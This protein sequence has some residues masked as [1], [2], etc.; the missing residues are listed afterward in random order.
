MRRAAIYLATLAT[1]SALTGAFAAPAGAQEEPDATPTSS[2]PSTTAGSETP[3]SSSAEAPSSAPGSTEASKSP[4]GKPPAAKAAARAQVDVSLDFD[5][6]SYGT[7]ED[8]TF[9]LKLKNTG[10]TTAT[11][12]TMYQM[13]S[14]PTD[15][16]VPYAG[17]GDLKGWPG[18]TLQPD[19]TFDLKVSGKVRDVEQATAVVRGALFD[20]SGAS[21]SQTFS[22]STPVT[23]VAGRAVGTVY[24]D[25]NG[26]GELDGGEQLAGTKLTLR[27]VQSSTGQAY[28]ATSDADGKFSF[29]VPAGDYYLGGDVVDGWLFPFRTVHIGP[30][31]DDM[32]VRGVPPLNGA[33]KASIAFTQDSYQVGDTAHLTV[34]LANSGPIPLTGIVAECNRIGDPYILAG[35]GPGW[36]DLAW[37]RGVTIGAGE[38]RTFDVTDTVPDAAY[39]R[40]YVAAY[41][42]FGYFEVDIDNHAQAGDQAAVPGAKA[43]IVGDV[44]HVTDGGARQG[45]AGVKLVLTADRHCPVIGEQTTD[46]QGHFEFHGLVPG[47]DYKLYLVP[48]QGW[49]VKYDNPTGVNVYGPEENPARLGFDVEPGDAQ[50]PAVPTNPADCTATPAPGSGSGS[51]GGGESGGGGGLAST[52]VDAI[53]LGA[54]ALV[55]LGLGGGLLVGT[56]RR[57]RSA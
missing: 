21:A 54:L 26:N 8:V 35:D 50:A 55:A 40:G 30:D 24:G 49:Q 34:T 38:T 12:L 42:D 2:A 13:S 27:Y 53:S 23:K 47:L 43:A 36:G 31:S 17:W 52:G 3:P 22:F 48:P 32:L 4:A 57:R 28:T 6:P 19:E 10:G 33:L 11:G 56:R 51:G 18:V 1:A 45:V 20:A 15:L 44:T 41:C 9:T 7:G 46:D 37:N 25:K 5:K 14:D 39:N 29:D 16:V